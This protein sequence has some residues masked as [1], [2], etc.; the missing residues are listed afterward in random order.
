MQHKNRKIVAFVPIKLNSERIPG[1]NLKLLGG[2]PLYQ[3][4]LDAL[5]RVKGIEEVYVFCSDD[6]I[7]HDLPPNVKFLKRDESLDSNETLGQ[8]IYSSFIEKVEAE[9]YVLAHTTSP[10]I[11]SSN[12]DLS[13]DK[14]VS[15]EFDSAF[16]VH[17]VMNF[18]WYDDKPINY[19]LDNIPRTQDLKP[20]YIETSGFFIFKSS[21]WSKYRQRIGLKPFKCVVNYIEAIDID[22]PDDFL[23]AEL[24]CKS[25]YTD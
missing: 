5:L 20:L 3:Y 10:F 18:A 12:I 13:I 11:N 16:S 6:S 1:K 22:E 2:K 9:Y 17:K 25:K 24:V 4:I 15:G 7:A 8:E 19:S 14:V 23:L 21:V